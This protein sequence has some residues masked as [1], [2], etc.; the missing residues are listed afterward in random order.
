VA[1]ETD[2]DE[3]VARLIGTRRQYKRVTMED[4]KRWV[5]LYRNRVSILKIATREGVDPGTVSAWLRKR[6]VEVKQGQHYVEQPPLALSP[7]MLDLTSS[8]PKQVQTF[9]ESCVWGFRLSE[10]GKEQLDKFCSFVKMHRLGK[11]VE[12]ISSELGVHRTSVTEWRKGTDL[13]YAIKVVRSVIERPA[14]KGWESIPLNLES[15]GNSQSGWLHVP[16]VIRRYSDIVAVTN[17]LKPLDAAFK[18]A[19]YFGISPGD[20][21]SLR[22]DLFAYV[23]GVMLG[24]SGKLGG[25]LERFTS[26][27]L[28]LQLTLKH[29]SNKRMG[30]FVCMAVNCLGIKMERAT[31]KAAS[32]T[33]RFGRNPSAA[34]RWLSARSPLIAWL[35]VAGLGLNFNQTTSHDPV[36]M[37]WI[38]K[39]PQSFRTRFIQGLADSDGTVKPSEVVIASMPNAEFITLLLRGL[40]MATAHTVFEAGRPLRTMVN[41]REAGT[42]PIFNEYIRSYRYGKMQGLDGAEFDAAN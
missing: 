41:R 37:N 10:D 39:T 18:R 16:K 29:A 19:S 13:P 15:G 8:G 26:A 32:G 24:D 9:L 2:E 21:M 33:S 6:G 5:E 27:S 12:E 35:F 28:D 31:D 30:E 14:P 17:Q 36:H 3:P 22:F 1:V 7:R 34:Y 11:G 38:H 4:A 20:M 23:L 25:T 42:L 40:G